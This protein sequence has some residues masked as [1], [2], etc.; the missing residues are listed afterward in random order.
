[1]NKWSDKE[2]EL[3]KSNAEH[4]AEQ[5]EELRLRVNALE[6]FCNENSDL[7]EFENTF[8][9]LIEKMGYSN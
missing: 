3:K 8:R 2:K 5:K 7:L 4:E 9:G 1:M 6:L